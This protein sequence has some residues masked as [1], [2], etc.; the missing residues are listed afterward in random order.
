MLTSQEPSPSWGR[1]L[2][3]LL[4]LGA[5]RTTQGPEEWATSLQAFSQG[6]WVLGRLKGRASVNTESQ[7]LGKVG[8]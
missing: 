8:L 3:H 6:L 7:G 2:L 4:P 5:D 1:A